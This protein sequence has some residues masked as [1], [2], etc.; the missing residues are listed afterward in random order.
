MSQLSIFLLENEQQ[1]NLYIQAISKVHVKNHPE[2]LEIQNLYQSILG[3]IKKGPMDVVYE[4]RRLDEI[5]DHFTTP[6]DA[7][8]TYDAVIEFLKEA[9]D[10]HNELVG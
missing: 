3:K 9:F 6:K 8:Q 7:C 10:L 5:T 1:M 4:F 2:V